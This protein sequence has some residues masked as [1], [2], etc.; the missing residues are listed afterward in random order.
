MK[1]TKKKTTKKAVSKK[2]SNTQVPQEPVIINSVQDVF[3]EMEAL[4]NAVS[5]RAYEL[6]DGRGRQP[7]RDL[8]D[9][10]KAESEL[11]LKP[12]I[13]VTE[14]GKKVVINAK[15]SDFSKDELEVA[16]EPDRVAICGSKHRSS[17]KRNGQMTHSESYAKML[18]RVVGLPAKVDTAKAKAKLEK[19]ILHIEA[20]KA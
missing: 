5:Q 16:M 12:D 19:G 10:L 18:S 9:W 13:E 2:S 15:V 8:E 6:F 11:M 3:K 7:G 1:A 4:Y 20:P 14:K 17:K